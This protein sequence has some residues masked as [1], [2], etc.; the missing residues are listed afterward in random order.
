LVGHPFVG[1]NGAVG[2]KELDNKNVN[3]TQ[4]TAV[5]V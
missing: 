5:H 3:R 1:R 4:S 2:R